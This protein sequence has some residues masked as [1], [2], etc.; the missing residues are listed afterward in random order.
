MEHDEVKDLSLLGRISIFWWILA[1]LLVA[2][3]I[4]FFGWLRPMWLGQE[5]NAFTHSHQYIESKKAEII[6]NMEKYDELTADI[7]KYK[8]SGH[9]DIAEGLKAQQKSLATK[10][11]NALLL[12]PEDAWPEGSRRFR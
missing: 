1:V 8:A 3:T 12:V 2:G 10:I 11:R 6:T 4:T 5:R 9:E 7:A